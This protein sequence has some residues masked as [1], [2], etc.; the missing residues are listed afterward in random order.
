MELRPSLCI[1][2]ISWAQP[3]IWGHA[4][5]GVEESEFE[6]FCDPTNQGDCDEAL[7]EVKEELDEGTEGAEGPQYETFCD[8][9]KGQL[10]S[11]CPFGVFKYTK[12]P[13]KLLYGFLP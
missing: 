10:I 13:T 4:N 8:P 5:E 9:T 12:K 3:F 2:E 7:F 1:P 6:K 11:K